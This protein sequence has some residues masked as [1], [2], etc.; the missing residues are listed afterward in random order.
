VNGPA[1]KPAPRRDEPSA[2]IS[3]VRPVSPT[4][5]AN[6]I[7]AWRRSI[8]ARQLRE[9]LNETIIVVL[10]VVAIFAAGAVLYILGNDPGRPHDALV[11]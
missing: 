9:L 3:E 1:P 10:V 4:E 2:G 5:A 6:N 7:A 8:I 11:Q